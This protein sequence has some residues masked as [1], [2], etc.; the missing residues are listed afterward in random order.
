MVLLSI[1][2][3]PADLTGSGILVEVVFSGLLPSE[4]AFAGFGSD[5]AIMVFGLLVLTAALARTGVVE[6][7][8]RA[9]LRF[10]GHNARRLRAAIT[11][12]LAAISA[13]TSNTSASALSMPVL[14]GLARRT[15]SRDL[16]KPPTYGTMPLTLGDS[17]TVERMTLDH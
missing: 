4:H 11:V 7:I 16:Q 1:D 14:L 6:S 10:A 8:G 17:L 2:R 3:I 9:T 5:T 13:I 12:F 15:R